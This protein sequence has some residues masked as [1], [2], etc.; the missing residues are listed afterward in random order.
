MLII[1]IADSI[2]T[3]T[4]DRESRRNALCEEMVQAFV[5]ALASF[6]AAGVR[7]VVFRAKPGSK[8]WSA[9]HDID[10]L[11]AAGLDPLAWRDPLRKLVREIETFSAPVIAMIE[12]SVW[13]GACETVFACDLILAATDATFAATPAKL[14]VPYN[15][16]GLLT[17]LNAANLRIGK[18]MLFTADPIPAERLCSL[19][20]INQVVDKAE[21]EEHTYAMA[22]RIAANAPLSISVMKEQLRILAGAH[23]MS[24][25]DFERIQG[26]RRVVYNSADYAEGIRAFK[27]KRKPVFKGE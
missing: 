21:L 2:G 4:L 9:G 1:D 10:E 7:C 19:G 22:R 5:A 23:T 14:N 17:F 13:G 6:T 20:I 11:P 24:P 25:E 8:V 3:I 18:E 16:G 12:G 26:L 27:E 15:V